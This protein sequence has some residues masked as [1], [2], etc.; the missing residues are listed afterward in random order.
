[1]SAREYL[2][3]LRQVVTT[4][5]VL[6]L[7]CLGGFRNLAQSGIRTFLPLYL[8]Q[9]MAM[10]PFLFGLTLF[11]LQMGGIVAS[12]VAGIW[13]DRIGR[14]PVLLAGLGAATVA[15][16]VLTLIGDPVMFIAGVSV[17]GFALFAVRPVLQGWMMDLTPSALGGSATSL[18]FG[19]QALF[20]VMAPAIGG[21]IADSH[22]LLVVFYCLAGSMCIA[23]LLGYLL[24]KDAPTRAR[25]GAGD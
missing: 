2:A 8:I 19:V 9:V 20:S 3:G 12:P 24:P 14:R 23:N 7:C 21:L 17:L 15:I 4:P 25:A 6:L 5:S 18:M 11:S 16:V 13:S 22:G 1:M 10:G